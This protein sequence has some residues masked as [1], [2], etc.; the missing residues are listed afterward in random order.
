MHH[1]AAVKYKD[2]YQIMGLNRDATQ[3]EI[4]RAHRKLARKYHPDVSK[5]SDAEAK[6]KEVGEAYEVLKDPEKRAA[7]DRLDPNMQADQEF[8]PPPGWDSGFEFRGG[9]TASA[10]GF[11]NF[12]EQLFGQQDFRAHAGRKAS[13]QDHHAKVLVDLNDVFHGATRK[14]TL[15]SPELDESGHVRL[16]SRTLTIKIPKGMKEGQHLRLKGQGATGM[17]QQERGDLYLEM[18]FN[19]HSFYRAEGRDLYFQLP[20]SP[21]EAA[22]G[23]TV[24]TP[25]PNGAVGV[26]IP[27]GSSSG[28]KLRLKGRGIPGN[29]A[30]DIYVTLNVVVP[31]ANTEQA[32]ALYKEMESKLA[33]NPRAGM[34]V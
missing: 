1:G 20:V 10:E 4:K 25:T 33:F 6:F 34:G 21:W 24:Q 7:Y 23:A 19:P 17:G 13:G 5:E 26:K 15:Q 16:I 30:G 28:N 9:G 27:A 3:D 32:K 12:F 14:I 31:P 22:L 2:Y 8:Q 29:P 18:H 11:S